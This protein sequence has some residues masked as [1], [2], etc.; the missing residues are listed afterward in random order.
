MKVYTARQA[1]LNRNNNVSAYELFFRNSTQNIFPSTVDDHE[2]TAKLIGRTYFNKGIKPFTEGKRALINF[3]EESL[4]KRL[5]FFL[6]KD[7]IV[8]EILET[9]TPSD[10]V[11][12]IC[13][14]L[15]N[16]GYILALD[17]FIYKPQWKRFLT[18]VRIIKFDI[19]QTPLDT[20]APLINELKNKT[21]IRLLAEKVETYQ[22]YKQAL[23]L[24]FHLFQGFYFCKPEMQ[25]SKEIESTS[26]LLIMLF[27]EVNKPQM[28]HAII[29][30]LLERD[31]NLMFKLLCYVNSGIFPIKGKINSVKQAI[32][33][34][35][36]SQLKALISLFFIAVLAKDKPSELLSICASRAKFCELVINQ[37]EP[38]HHES[39][40]MT[41]MFSLIDAVL[42]IPIYDVTKRLS[43]DDHICETLLDTT[44]TSQ[45]NISMALRTIKYLEQGSW[46][47][48]EREALKLTIPID[49][50]NKYYQTA[51]QWAGYLN[52]YESIEVE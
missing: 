25:E 18:I 7:E 13:S 44:D 39:A 4:L 41:G 45:T 19:Q 26:M 42:D 12:K 35:G 46:Y 3:S 28:N 6:P 5:P 52:D 27:K 23:A 38:I 20:I 11:F 15:Y 47:L 1:I 34:M 50:I 8:I 21:R 49:E 43:L 31:C 37:Q 2:A 33:Y 24:G 14:E 40:F 30:E 29:I 22:E 48:A 17:D 10:I 32:T 51:I 9:V 36:E 16:E